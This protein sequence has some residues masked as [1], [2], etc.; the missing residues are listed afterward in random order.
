LEFPKVDVELS[1]DLS[2]NLTRCLVERSVDVGLLNGPIADFNINNVEL[3]SVPLI[4]VASPSLHLS[5]E[6]IG[7]LAEHTILTHARH[8]RPYVEIAAH[9]RENFSGPIRLVPSGSLAACLQ[10]TIDGLG[11]ATLPRSLVQASI[12]SGEL[13]EFDCAWRPNPLIYTASYAHTPASFLVRRAAELARE[14]A[15]MHR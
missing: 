15:E 9:F 8:T 13:V 6:G 3:G 7:V 11:V 2:I 14:I 4:W 1:V 10:M 12:E 5:G